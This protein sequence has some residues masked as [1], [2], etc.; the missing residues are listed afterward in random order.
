MRVLFSC[1]A[2]EGHVAPLVPL[3]RAFAG[4]GHDVTFATACQEHAADSVLAL[5]DAV[6]LAPEPWNGMYRGAYIDICPPSL[7]GETVP[8]VR[9]PICDVRRHPPR[10]HPNRRG[11]LRGRSFRTSM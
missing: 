4:L 10:P 2:T 5:W 11:N 9:R 1:T 7:A 3:A 6:G 8:T